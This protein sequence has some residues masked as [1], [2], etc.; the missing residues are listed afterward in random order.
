[1]PNQIPKIRQLNQFGVIADIDPYDLPPNA[2]SYAQ[3]VR[4][5]NGRVLSGPVFK[6]VEHLQSANPRFMTAFIPVS[7]Q[8]Q[9]FLGYENGRVFLF[10]PANNT[11]TDYS[12]TGFVNSVVEGSW[13]S[14]LLANCIYVN[15]P[16]RAPWALT[17]GGVQFATLP[18]W[19]ANT[20]CGLFRQCSGALVAL[21]MTESGVNTPNKLR[22]STFAQAGSVP[23]SWDYTVPGTNST[24]NI[25]AELEG[26]IIDAANL[27]RDLIIYSIDQTWRMT[28]SGD[29]NVFNYYKLPFQLGALNANCV[30][31]VNSQHFVFGSTDIWVHDGVSQRSIAE[32]RVKDFI[33]GSINMSASNR[34]FVVHNMHTSEIHF[35]YVSGDA[36]CKF[37]PIDG[38]ACNRQAV[39]NY[40]ND[41]W[42]FD[43][44]P[45][46]YYADWM[47]LDSVALWSTVSQTWTQIQGSWQSQQD[48]QKRLTSYIGD[49]NSTYSL[50]ASL[51]AFDPYASSLPGAPPS[52]VS[53]SVDT[54][55][56]SYPYLERY[57]IDLD[58]VGADLQGYK[59]LNYVIPLGRIDPLSSQMVNISFGAADGFGQTPTFQPYMGI[60]FGPVNYKL[61][62]NEAGRW[63]AMKV[64]FNDFPPMTLSGFDFDMTVTGER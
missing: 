29:S 16:D 36:Y 43:D 48:T 49:T 57:G 14:C 21:N 28:A 42:S 63:L 55:A 54:N 27:G 34:C 39:Y 50:T 51:Y 52:L 37:A 8:D 10:N 15:R 53:Y 44:L 31:Q 56:S 12:I 1:M 11:E 24:F 45:Y 26:D 47:N 23:S 30:V 6:S 62:M 59:L 40:A 58:Q 4:F 19:P 46:V 35:C 22:T 5:R 2:F 25:L 38:G 60:D 3:N 61:D 32:G 9:I 64:Q 41:T 7:G 17:P 20:T 18:N 33:Y 13:T